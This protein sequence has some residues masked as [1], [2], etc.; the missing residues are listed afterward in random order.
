[1]HNANSPWTSE[2]IILALRLYSVTPY[3]KISAKNPEIKELATLLGRSA[4]AV[5]FKLSN[6]AA[7]D[8][9]GQSL[10]HKGSSHGNK[11]EPIIWNRYL[12][13]DELDIEKLHSDAEKIKAGILNSKEGTIYTSA[14]KTTDLENRPFRDQDRFYMVKQRLDQNL[15]RKA[16]LANFDSRCPFSGCAIPQLI[17]AAHI[18]PWNDYPNARMKVSNGL[19]LN[20]LIHVAY[21]KDLLGI[22]P[23][24][25]VVVSDLLLANVSGEPC[26][27]FFLRIKDHCID[28][29]RLRFRPNPDFL[30]ER[31]KHYQE[32]HQ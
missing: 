5:S 31:F 14:T 4:G 23:D 24:G 8:K 2:E 16:V 28:F 20:K 25:R 27:D 30:H 15:F 26:R 21:D 6:L 13:D 32:V 1:M 10:G 19:A 9:K 12:I 17:D 3:S 11:L 18:L 29:Q 7:R 22:D